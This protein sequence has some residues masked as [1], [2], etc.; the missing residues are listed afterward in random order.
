MPFVKGKGNHGMMWVE[1]DLQS[2][3]SPAP[4]RSGPARAGHVGSCPIM[5]SAS[6]RI[7]NVP[8]GIEGL[9]AEIAVVQMMASALSVV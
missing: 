3:S 8:E 2:S 5:L 1:T 6:P 4:A 9:E 7:L